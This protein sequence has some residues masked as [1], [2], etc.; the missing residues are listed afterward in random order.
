[1]E[2]Q[3]IQLVWIVVDDL[4]KSIRFYTDVLGYTILQDSREM[5]WMELS[6]GND[7]RLGIAQ[8]NDM[9]QIPAG[10]NAIITMTVSD[11]SKAIEE[12]SRKGVKLIGEMIEIPGHVKM[13]TIQ[14]LDGNKLQLVQML[15]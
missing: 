10:S 15:S 13:Q 11:I 12:I 14:D 9:D 5:G 8:K 7:M 3:G 4:E 6:C 2:V 1:M